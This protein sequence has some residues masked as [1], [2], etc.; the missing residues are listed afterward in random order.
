MSEIKHP[1]DRQSE[2]REDKRPG[3]DSMSWLR[4]PPAA[5]TPAA[6]GRLSINRRDHRAARFRQA[7]SM[8]ETNGSAHPHG[9]FHDEQ[10]SLNPL[11]RA[12]ST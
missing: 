10:N 12:V 5:S 9:V 7:P 4:R 1:N 8:V 2:P 11:A 6:K 3:P